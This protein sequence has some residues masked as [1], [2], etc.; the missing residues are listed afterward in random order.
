MIRLQAILTN[1]ITHVLTALYTPFGFSILSAVL[2][3]FLYILIE[4]HGGGI[5]GLKIVMRKWWKLFRTDVT[6]HRA[7]FL[8]FYTVLILFQ[9]LLNRQLCINPL[10]DVMGEWGLMDA[11]G[12]M[13]TEGIENIIL[14]IPFIILLFWVFHDKLYEKKSG[15]L[16]TLWQSGKV[17]FLFSA[18]I[19]FLQ[20]FLRLG[21]FQISDLVYNTLGGVIGGVIYWLGSK[22]RNWKL[23]E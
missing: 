8:A 14:F 7:F 17:T 9:T 16:W 22:V 20:L 19:E 1:I 10:S 3:M 11:N 18:G 13:S 2:F 23:K 6:F 12:Q 15:L 4:E 5:S 21:S